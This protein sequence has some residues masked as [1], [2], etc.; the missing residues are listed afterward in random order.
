MS[1]ETSTADVRR[2]DAIR[3][4]VVDD[5]PIA[6]LGI[7]HVLSAASHIEVVCSTG[8]VAEL[9][10]ELERGAGLDAL[11]L[12]LYL[13]GDTPALAEVA[14]LSR[15][16]RVLIMSASGR[17]ADVLGAIRAGANG[18]ITKRSS[19][20]LIVST[21][22]TVAAGGFLLSGELADV[23]Q[24]EL[25]RHAP[26]PAPSEARPSLSPR[27]EQTLNLVAKGFTHAQIATRLDVRKATVDTYVERIRAKLQLGN[28]A[29]LTRAALERLAP[30]PRERP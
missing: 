15:T 26:P 17:A 16:N 30:P 24:N 9:G 25:V 11:I 12:D 19:P 7:E 23:I 13:D 5:H 18:Y 6:R 29:E 27:E 10:R 22:E 28:K 20:E 14:E 4:A 8:S 3:V 1:D 2:D 21:V